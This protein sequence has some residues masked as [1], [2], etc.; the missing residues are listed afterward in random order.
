M[1][2]SIKLF[3]IVFINFLFISC[4]FGTRMVNLENPISFPETN[5][6][7]T[8]KSTKIK[9]DGFIN[10]REQVS[11]S[12]F[13]IK[14]DKY[15]LIGH[16]RNTYYMP[17]ANV[18]SYEDAVNWINKSVKNKI[19]NSGYEIIENSKIKSGRNSSSDIS[20]EGNVL[21]VYADSYFNFDGRVSIEIIF[22]RLNTGEVLLRKVYE[23]VNTSYHLAKTPEGFKEVLEGSLKSII[24][25]MFMDLENLDSK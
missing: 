1:F 6:Q 2:Q 4:A 10:K 11:S 9:F 7:K 22:K 12:W 18:Y 23:E 17:T 21:L 20:I 16:V 25:S 5:T 3:I 13:E 15:D 19:L 8:S 14:S 24:Y